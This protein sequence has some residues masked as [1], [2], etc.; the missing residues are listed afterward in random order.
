M[1]P[2]IHETHWNGAV[3]S[4]KDYKQAISG[5]FNKQPFDDPLAELMKLRQVGTVEQYQ[6]AFDTLLTRIDD[7]SISH[8]INCF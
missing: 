8:A 3:P 6:D 2:N 4:W 5:R 1:A 7:L